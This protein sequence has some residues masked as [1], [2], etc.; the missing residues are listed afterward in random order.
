MNLTEFI[1]NAN[2]FSREVRREHLKETL[3][4]TSQKQEYNILL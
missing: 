3:A 2:F 1:R 4:G